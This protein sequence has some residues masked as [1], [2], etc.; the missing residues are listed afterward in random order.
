MEKRKEKV[1]IISQLKKEI[2][3]I[4]KGNVV[5]CKLSGHYRRR[6]R[7]IKILLDKLEK[8]I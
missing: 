1:K 8:I 2:L 3:A 7:K 4:Q 5:H 6:S